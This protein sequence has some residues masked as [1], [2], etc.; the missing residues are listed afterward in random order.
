MFSGQ[1]APPALDDLAA[2]IS[3]RALLL[4][5]AENGGGGEDLTPDYYAAAGEPKSLWMVP[6]GEHTGG[7]TE[8][9]QEYAQRVGTFFAQALLQ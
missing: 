4:I 7:L 5:H 8:Q 9:P 6:G 1:P 3:P 2:R